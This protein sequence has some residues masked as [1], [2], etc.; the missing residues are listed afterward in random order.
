LLL[1]LAAALDGQVAERP[2]QVPAAVADRIA[3][4]IAEL[5]RVDAEAIH[6]E[7]GALLLDK[8]L[9][10]DVPFRVVGR[11]TDGWF[12]VVFDS[13]D[14]ATIAARVHAGFTDTVV[15]ATRPLR[16][17]TQL[18][19]GDYERT[20]RVRWGAPRA[21]STLPGPGW[22]V[23]RNVAPGTELST[24]AVTEPFAITVG[25][26]VRLVWRRGAVEISLSGVAMNAA[27]VGGQ[28]RARVEGRSGRMN[29]VVT[30][31]GM[32]TI[33]GGNR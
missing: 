4:S 23:R 30:A 21:R 15:T 26:P 19:T 3:A 2:A 17:G 33:I 10:H 28:V 20:V 5:W 1:A 32:A 6:L 27:R 11:G 25:D 16:S 7:W 14:Q 24:P 22:E 29:A 8:Q 9:S 18:Q 12:A 31:P 13:K